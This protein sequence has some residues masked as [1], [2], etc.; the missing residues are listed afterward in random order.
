[1]QVLFPDATNT[2]SKADDGPL[3]LRG[4]FKGT[5]ILL[6]DDLSRAGQSELLSLTNDLHA[7]IVIAGLP[8]EGEPLNNALVEAI[9]P[10]V[11]IIADSEFPATRRASRALHERLAAMKIPVIYTR[12]SGAVKIV[13]DKSGWRA[14]AMDG[15]IFNFP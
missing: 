4:D 2:P 13:M 12:T 15:Q 7:D 6:L 11:I 10:K 8:M 9:Q 1:M 14:R 5:K 3:V